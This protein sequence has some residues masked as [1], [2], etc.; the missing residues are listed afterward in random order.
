MQMSNAVEVIGIGDFRQRAT[1]LIRRVEETSEPI[2]ISRR[3]V[4]VVEL[5]PLELGTDDLVGSVTPIGDVDLW[6][7]IGEPADWS[8]SH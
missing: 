8:G 2:R 5:R 3:G 1:E 6:E 7:P 4:P